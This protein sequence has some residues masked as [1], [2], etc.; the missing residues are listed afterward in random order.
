MMSLSCFTIDSSDDL[1]ISSQGYVKAMLLMPL[2]NCQYAAVLLPTLTKSSIDGIL[3]SST[4]AHW[5]VFKIWNTYLFYQEKYRA[6]PQLNIEY[7]WIV[8]IFIDLLDFSRDSYV[9]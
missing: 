7:L 9:T 1:V 2:H 5:H 4:F 6:L 8:S 3:K